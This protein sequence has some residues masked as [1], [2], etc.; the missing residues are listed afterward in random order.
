MQKLLFVFMTSITLALFAHQANAS[1][2]VNLNEPGGVPGTGGSF[3]YNPG[4]YCGAGLTEVYSPI[5][6]FASG[7]IVNFGHLDIFTVGF[8]Q[9]TPDAGP[10]QPN[11]YLNGN[12]AV[13]FSSTPSFPAPTIPTYFL[14][15]VSDTSCNFNA[16][17]YIA[18][19]NLIFTIPAGSDSIQIKWDAADYTY[20]PA[21]PEPSTWAMLLI[22]FAALGLLSRWRIAM[23][24]ARWSSNRPPEI[25]AFAQTSGS[26]I[27][28]RAAV[29]I[30]RHPARPTFRSRRCD[31]GVIEYR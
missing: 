19:F 26:T 5:Y 22:G 14:C 20:T 1:V 30:S 10:S 29:A 7:S 21:V 8:G 17:N 13:S 24:H 9:S 23:D 28:V 31:F 18:S 27:P 11:L 3:P 4:C 16:Q 2:I 15:N 25:S 6:H 12:F